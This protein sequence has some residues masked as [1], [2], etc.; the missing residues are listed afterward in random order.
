MEILPCR[1]YVCNEQNFYKCYTVNWSSVWLWGENT[2]THCS[3]LLCNNST[4]YTNSLSLQEFSSLLHMQE[5]KILLS[6]GFIQ[7]REFVCQTVGLN[8][9]WQFEGYNIH[10]KWRSQVKHQEHFC[11][12][13]QPRGRCSIT[14]LLTQAK[15]W[16]STPKMIKWWQ[17]QNWI[18]HHPWQNASAPIFI[19]SEHS[20]GS[21]ASSH[22][23]F[24]SLWFIV[25]QNETAHFR[26]LSSWLT[27]N[28]EITADGPTWHTMKSVLVGASSSGRNL[29]P[30]YEL[31]R[32]LF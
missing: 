21:P 24:H 12:L 8:Q 25:S 9:K 14:N 32:G 19:H 30:L 28:S 4:H 15:Q 17:D 23:W 6:N 5:I 7:Q 26:A 18:F 22:A 3:N 27:W 10:A 31:G 16:T 1:V 29:D 2:S 20:C 11:N 13:F